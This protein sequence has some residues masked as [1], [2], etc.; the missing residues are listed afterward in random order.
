MNRVANEIPGNVQFSKE[1]LADVAY[2]LSCILKVFAF[3]SFNKKLLNFLVCSKQELVTKYTPV[4]L[5]EYSKELSKYVVNYATSLC[6][7]GLTNELVT[8]FIIEI[9]DFEIVISQRNNF[10]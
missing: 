3:V 2:K 7:Y 9:A 8:G 4:Q 5:L 1:S 6:D 10:V